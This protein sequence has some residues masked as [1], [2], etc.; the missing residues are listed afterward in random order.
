MAAPRA[1]PA[2]PRPN[3]F[4]SVVAYKDDNRVVADTQAIHGVKSQPDI[5]IHFGQHVGP[6]TVA[7]LSRK[8]RIVGEAQALAS[9]FVDPRRRRAAR[10]SPAVD[11]QFAVVDENEQD[12]GFLDLRM[13]TCCSECREH[14]ESRRSRTRQHC[15]GFSAIAFHLAR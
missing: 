5:V 2:V 13:G 15:D 4:R 6:V 7:G 14:A 10:H 3:K 9:E 11:T 8:C 12:V 1:R